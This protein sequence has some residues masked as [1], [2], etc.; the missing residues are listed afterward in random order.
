MSY[1]I[2]NIM[3]SIRKE[4]TLN[5]LV[6]LMYVCLFAFKFTDACIK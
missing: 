5:E 2:I 6:N 4:K 3:F 1:F